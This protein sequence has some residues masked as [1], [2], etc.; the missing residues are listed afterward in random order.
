MKQ[1]NYEKEKKTEKGGIK[2]GIEG[3]KEETLD[4]EE[5]REEIE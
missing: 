4:E 1:E 2:E 5:E 3:I